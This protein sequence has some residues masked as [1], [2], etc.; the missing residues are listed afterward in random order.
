MWR[1]R[2]PWLKETNRNVSTEM[3]PLLKRGKHKGDRGRRCLL[4]PTMM[5][6]PQSS[7]DFDKRLFCSVLIQQK[8]AALLHCLRMN[9]LLWSRYNATPEFLLLFS[10]LSE[11]KLNQ[12][13]ATKTLWRSGQS[14]S[15]AS[16]GCLLALG[17][18]M[19]EL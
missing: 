4:S 6:A 1:L 5:K 9:L 13:F 14:S 18:L 3:C 12:T 7:E 17:C 19:S 2:K 16:E 8:P 15:G 11:K 10:H